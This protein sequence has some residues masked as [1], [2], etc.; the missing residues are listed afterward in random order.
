MINLVLDLDTGIDD[1]IALKTRGS[2]FLVSLALM[3]TLRWMKVL[4]IL[5]LYLV[6]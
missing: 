4:I 1:A 3:V 5:S 2:T 6:F